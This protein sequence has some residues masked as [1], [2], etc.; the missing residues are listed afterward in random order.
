MSE[1]GH[2][3]ALIEKHKELSERVE[4]E[5]KKPSTDYLTIAR[6]KKEKLLLKEKIAGLS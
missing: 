6:L 1:A 4:K 3:Q 2:L 5:E